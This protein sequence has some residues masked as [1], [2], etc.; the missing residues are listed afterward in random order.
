MKR[1]SWFVVALIFG[2]ALTMLPA[3]AF[4]QEKKVIRWKGQGSFVGSA[5]AAGVPSVSGSSSAAGEGW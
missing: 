1:N 3:Q 4:S 2:L 5:A